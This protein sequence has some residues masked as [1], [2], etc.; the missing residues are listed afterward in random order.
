MDGTKLFTRLL[1]GKFI[2]QDFPQQIMLMIYLHAWYADDGMRCQ[3][4]LFHPDSCPILD[5]D[6]LPLSLFHKM[7]FVSLIVSALTNQFIIDVQG[8]KS[9]MSIYDSFTL[10]EDEICFTC[11]ARYGFVFL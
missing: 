2:F 9:I 11:F 6:E 3:M 5:D 8:N 1:L 7:V 10:Q 4:C